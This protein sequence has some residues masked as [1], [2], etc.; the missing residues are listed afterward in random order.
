MEEQPAK[1]MA[2]RPA[3]ASIVKR[4]R[5]RKS[6]EKRIFWSPRA[7][8]LAGPSPEPPPN[9]RSPIARRNCAKKTPVP[10]WGFGGVQ[11]AAEVKKPRK[12][13]SGP[14]SGNVLLTESG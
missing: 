10:K 7:A 14:F 9:Y 11:A 13:R 2:N 5:P 1:P 3:A 12:R 8:V 4:R 6:T